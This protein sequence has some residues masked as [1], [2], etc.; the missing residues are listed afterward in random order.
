[1]NVN[2]KVI[3]VQNMSAMFERKSQI[4]YEDCKQQGTKDRALGDT[5]GDRRP[6][7]KGIIRVSD[8]LKSACEI[9]LKPDKNRGV[10]RQFVKEQGVVN[11][12]EGFSEVKED[13]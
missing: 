7:R 9:G 1:M 11:G 5:R 8:S 3:G 2:L 6:A 13:E 12:V 4:I 10:V